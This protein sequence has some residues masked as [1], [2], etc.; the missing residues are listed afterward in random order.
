MPTFE[1]NYRRKIQKS[2]ASCPAHS[3]IKPL[4]QNLNLTRIYLDSLVAQ[5][6]KKPTCNTGDPGSI[7]GKT[8]LRRE[9][10][11]TLALLPESSHGQ[12]SLSGYSQSP[13]SLLFT[14]FAA[15]KSF[16]VNLV[17]T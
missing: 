2:S 15:S 1:V 3:A 4:T 10:Q 14:H 12:R 13:C 6:V 9:W 8:S 17:M 11:P 7:P 5:L 16:S